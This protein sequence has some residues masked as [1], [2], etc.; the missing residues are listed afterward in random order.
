MTN[1][2]NATLVK[3]LHQAACAPRPPQALSTLSALSKTAIAIKSK[4]V[5][6]T[7]AAAALMLAGAAQAS[8]VGSSVSVASNFPIPPNLAPGTPTVQSQIKRDPVTVGSGAEFTYANG[9]LGSFTFDFDETSLT[10]QY[11]HT[12]DLNNRPGE[13]DEASRFIFP[14]DTVTFSFSGMTDRFTVLSLGSVTGSFQNSVT[15]QDFTQR[16]GQPRVYLNSFTTTTTTKQSV[17]GAILDSSLWAFTDNTLSFN[18]GGP[19]VG[20][21]SAVFMSDENFS[22]K[23]VFNFALVPLNAT[24]STQDIPEPESLALMGLALAAL[25]FTRRK[26]KQA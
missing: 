1:N 9:G 16:R 26:A 5:L 10:M 25:G 11:Q 12:A 24:A 2:K 13:T 15:T 14:G 20:R 3:T 18:F 23:M 17:A 8:L 21:D 22:A 19:E 7:L 4:N 6:R